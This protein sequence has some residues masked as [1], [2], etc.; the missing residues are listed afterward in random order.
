MARCACLQFLTSVFGPHLA[1]LL[2]IQA[3]WASPLHTILLVEAAPATACRHWLST[4]QTWRVTT[5]R[6]AELQLLDQRAWLF[7]GIQRLDGGTASVWIATCFRA[8]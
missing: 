4:Y 2:H 1:A 6:A 3:V 8:A 7:L 5:N